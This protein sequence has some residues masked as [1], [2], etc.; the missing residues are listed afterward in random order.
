MLP[1]EYVLWLVTVQTTL[2]DAL[3]STSVAA[4]EAGGITQ[5]CLICLSRNCCKDAASHSSLARFLP[6]LQQSVAIGKAIDVLSLPNSQ[7]AANLKV[8]LSS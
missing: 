3:R 1:A 2:L 8:F 4:G 5:V 6:S 7:G